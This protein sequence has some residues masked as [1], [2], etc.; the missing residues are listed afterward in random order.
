MVTSGRLPLDAPSDEAPSF[1][2][3]RVIGC[4][5]RYDMYSTNRVFPQPVGPLNST[6]IFDL[7]AASNSSTSSPMGT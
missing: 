4:P 1:W 7:Y 5:R 6:G 3:I 2:E